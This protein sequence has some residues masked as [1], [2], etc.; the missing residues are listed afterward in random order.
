MKGLTFLI[1]I[2]VVGVAAATPTQGG[3]AQQRVDLQE[4]EF[5]FV[6]STVTLKA[7]VPA[8][9]RLWNRGSVE[10]EF[11]VNNRGHMHMAGMDP[12]KM[13]EELEKQSY[14]RGL[15]VRVEG[16]AKMVERRGKGLAMITLAPGEQVVLR[17][18][19]TRKGTFE[20]ECHLPGHYEAGMK[21]TWVVR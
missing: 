6:P 14:F 8:E 3:A 1:V 10:H 20:M 9:V 2:A 21:G 17:F 15:A 13:H 4:K 11:M 19:P 5:A 16:K 18:V 12:Q 7:G